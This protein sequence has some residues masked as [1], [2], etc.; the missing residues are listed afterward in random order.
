MNKKN[1]RSVSFT[2]LLAA[3]LLFSCTEKSRNLGTFAPS[4]HKYVLGQ[5]GV[6]PIPFSDDLTLWT[7]GDTILGEWKKHVPPQAPFAKRVKIRTMISNTLGYTPTIR[8]DT[9][10]S[11]NFSFLSDKGTAIQVIKHQKHEDPLKIRHWAFDGIRIKNKLYIYYVTIRIKNPTKALNFSV[12]SS[13]L[14][15][16]DIPAGWKPGNQVDFKRLGPLFKGNPPAFGATT[17]AH[18][19]YLYLLGQYTT[20]DKKSPVKVGRVPLEKMEDAQS[21][22]FLTRRGRW[23]KDYRQADGFI[24]EIAGECSITYSRYRKR[25]RIIYCQILSGKLMKVE[26]ND[27]TK[28][29]KAARECIYVPPA[30]TVKDPAHAPW[31]YSGKEIAQFGNSIYIIYIHPVEYQPYLVEVDL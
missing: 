5:D 11:L 31:Y 14:A 12:E 9:I 26:F 8:P 16:W 10:E 24:D 4:R 28:L 30:V 19:G 2:L 27:F 15:R 3:L 23:I 7:F 29:G 21:Y 17:V 13:G 6:T 20:K 1:K 22:R 25:F 18:E